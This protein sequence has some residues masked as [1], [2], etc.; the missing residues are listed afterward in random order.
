MD[1]AAVVINRIFLCILHYRSIWQARAGTVLGSC[2]D[3]SS[4][5]DG[6]L[7]SD[8]EISWRILRCWPPIQEPCWAMVLLRWA[9]YKPFA[10]Q[11]H[12]LL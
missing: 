5:T 2:K 9:G 1:N 12:A 11:R 6:S 3:K 7:G 10:P 4:S 8:V